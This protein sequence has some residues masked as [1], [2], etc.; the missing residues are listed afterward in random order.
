MYNLLCICLLFAFFFVLNL[1]TSA[2]AAIA[3]RVFSPVFDGISARRRV[4]IIFWLRLLPTVFAFVFA[5]AF[6]LPSYLLF[7]PHSSGEIITIKLAAPALISAIGFGIAIYRAFG[8]WWATRR[9]SA[10][11]LKLSEQIT[12]ENVNIPVYCV[13]HPFP[14]IAV[15]GTFRPRMFVARQIFDSLSADEFKA[16]VAHENGHL[17]TYDNIKRILLRIC[18]DLLLFSAGNN[19][20][21]DWVE[22]SEAAADEYAAQTGDNAT[23]LNLA[24][25][26]VKIARIVPRGLTPAMPVGAF[27]IEE[28]NIDIT[29]RVRQL[30]KFT[31]RKQTFI[32]QSN[33]K[34]VFRLCLS[35]ISIV[36]LLLATNQNLLEQIHFGLEKIVA[37]LQ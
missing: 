34:F 33:L 31:D 26:L 24:S 6:F 23:A 29:R 18:R 22:T 5:T 30:L 7:E 17:A 9:L 1:L 35:S 21:R 8:A 19:L 20:D 32:Q 36:T 11:W 16:A 25:A 10:S 12:V 15:V 14:V 13:R 2:S 4:Q 28:K 37:V 3:W 27:L